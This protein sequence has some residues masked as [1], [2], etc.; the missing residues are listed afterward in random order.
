[1]FSFKIWDS[2]GL[3]QFVALES[4]SNFKHLFLRSGSLVDV[5]CDS[6]KVVCVSWECAP[7]NCDAD[8]Y[9][10]KQIRYL[11]IFI[12][13]NLPEIPYFSGC[14]PLSDIED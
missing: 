11:V 8:I 2:F 14:I 6:D 10:E 7:A 9:F 12:M 3:Q 4:V 1:M 5:N 13:T